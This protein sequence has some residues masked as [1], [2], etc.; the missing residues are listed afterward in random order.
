[1]A[2]SARGLRVPSCPVSQASVMFW[3]ILCFLSPGFLSDTSMFFSHSTTVPSSNRTARFTSSSV[4]GMTLHWTSNISHMDPSPASYHHS[5]STSAVRRMFPILLLPMTHSSSLKLYS[6]NF[7]TISVFFAR[8]ATARRM[9]PGGRIPYLSR[10]APVVPP[11]SA[12][13]M[14]AERLYSGFFLSP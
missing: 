2:S 12:T 14:I 11:L 10:I 7:R 6:N 9:S 13:E 4:T 3:S 8:A 5:M 1:M